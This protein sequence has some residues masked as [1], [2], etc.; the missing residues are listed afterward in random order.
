[1]EN[2]NNQNPDNKIPNPNNDIPEISSIPP[3]PNQE[4]I[5]NP[6]NNAQEPQKGF[7]QDNNQQ[8]FAQQQQANQQQYNQQQQQQ[9]NQQQQYNQQQY[10]AGN[11]NQQKLNYTPPVNNGY[12]NRTPMQI[13]V[14]NS[15]GVLTLGIL[16]ILTLCCC[17]PFLGPILAVIALFLVPKGMRAYNENPNLYKLSSFN[18]LKAGKICAI[19]GLSLGILLLIYFIVMYSIEPG[20]MSE[21]NEAFDQAWNEMGY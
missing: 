21:I 9:F 18:N 11:Q 13:S 17:G 8:Q 2:N 7:Q 19:I 6:V 10:N 16:S 5:N 20:N 1:M 3:L 15:A 4:P 14:P 12:Q